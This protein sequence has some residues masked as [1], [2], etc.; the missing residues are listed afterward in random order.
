L[1]PLHVFEGGDVH[2]ELEVHWTQNPAEQKGFGAEQADP[3]L[4]VVV[5]DELHKPAPL[6]P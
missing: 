5:P 3:A 1:L 2:W 6:Q 4:Q